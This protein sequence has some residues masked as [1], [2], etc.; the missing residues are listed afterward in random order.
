MPQSGV[1][2]TDSPAVASPRRP[3]FLPQDLVYQS[4][5]DAFVRLK[6][7]GGHVYKRREED[8]EQEGCEHT[9]LTKALF[10]SKPPRAHPV[11]ERHAYS[12]AIAELTNDRDHILS[13]AK[14]GDYC[15][16]KGSINGVVR[17]GKVDKA[18]IQR[19]SFLPR[20][21][22]QPTNHKHHI[23]GRRVLSETT[24]FLRQDP[25]A[26]TVLTEAASDDLQQYLAGVRYQRDTPEIAALCP[27]FLFVEYHD[28]DIFPLLYS[29]DFP[30]L[31]AHQVRLGPSSD[32]T[33][34]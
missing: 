25:R 28:G 22:L 4:V 31:A 27:I 20:Q 10:H 16:E 5:H 11:V 32:A 9:P 7:R 12:H 30:T 19:N 23:G 1:A 24:L 2:R 8:V 18:Y 33:K 15:P 21:L 6:T 34:V 29:A 13:H 14:M 26:L 17:F 3:P